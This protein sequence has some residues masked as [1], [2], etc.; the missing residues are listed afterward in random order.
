MKFDPMA[1]NYQLMNIK[2]ILDI[3][4]ISFIH[5]SSMVHTYIR[6][7]QDCKSLQ[8]GIGEMALFLQYWTMID[9][10][11]WPFDLRDF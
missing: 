10:I 4:Y 11:Y 6:F 2:P 8:Q 7:H 3:N 9:E 5:K 1:N